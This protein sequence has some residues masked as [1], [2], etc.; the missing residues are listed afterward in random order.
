MASAVRGRPSRS[1]Q[2]SPHESHAN[3]STWSL[4]LADRRPE[5]RAADMQTG[6][7]FARSGK[8]VWPGSEIT[9]PKCRAATLAP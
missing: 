4:S 1:N 5:V 2:N 6:H 3:R 8:L 7:A 9:P